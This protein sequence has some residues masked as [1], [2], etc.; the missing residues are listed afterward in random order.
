MGRTNFKTVFISLGYSGASCFGEV[1]VCIRSSSSGISR[2]ARQS[3][4]FKPHD[5]PGDK[6]PGRGG[7]LFQLPCL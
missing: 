6:G 7:A 2:K 3:E 5:K 4:A 1:D